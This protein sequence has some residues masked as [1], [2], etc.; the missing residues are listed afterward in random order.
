MRNNFQGK[1]LTLSLSD[2]RLQTKAMFHI[3]EEA[4]NRI[5]LRLCLES[6]E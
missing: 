1:F 5:E 4:T 6:L 3:L 2:H